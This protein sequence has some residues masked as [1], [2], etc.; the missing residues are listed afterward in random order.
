MYEDRAYRY[1]LNRSGRLTE[2]TGEDWDVSS[3]RN[4]YILH[5]VKRSRTT[6]V[7]IYFGKGS[8]P[9]LHDF[10]LL[11]KLTCIAKIFAYKHCFCCLNVQ[12]IKQKNFLYN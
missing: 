1:V 12:N 4:Q 6:V 8:F 3:G 11:Y 5:S 9:S 7:C 10:T 2:V